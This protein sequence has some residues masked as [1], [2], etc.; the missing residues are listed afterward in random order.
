[1]K[2][3]YL[4]LVATVL[5][6]TFTSLAYAGPTELLVYATNAKRETLLDIKFTAELYQEGNPT[7]LFQTDTRKSNCV[8]DAR[9]TGITCKG[10][11]VL[12][13]PSKFGPVDGVGAYRVVFK[14]HDGEVPVVV[15]QDI[16]IDHSSTS[17]ARVLVEPFR[18]LSLENRLF[19]TAVNRR[20]FVLY[21]KSFTTI[22]IKS[23]VVIAALS[24]TYQTLRNARKIDE[25]SAFLSLVTLWKDYAAI[26]DKELVSVFISDVRFAS[27]D[28]LN[29]AIQVL[30]DAGIDFEPVPTPGPV[31]GYEN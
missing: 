23:S 13:L 15:S 10:K 26:T 17:T 25:F 12:D 27:E 22:S 28:N 6:S 18:V 21:P 14:S 16:I 1:M 20:S 5:S 31:P 30:R 4:G 2:N 29:A 11:A 8:A 7:P 24:E 9:N 3:V 19:E